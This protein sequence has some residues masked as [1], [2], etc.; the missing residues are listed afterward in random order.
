MCGECPV[1][2]RFGPSTVKPGELLIT[3]DSAAL[4]RTGASGECK[5]DSSLP[6]RL[7]GLAE[8]YERPEDFKARQLACAM[9]LKWSTVQTGPTEKKQFWSKKVLEC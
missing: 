8:K 3:C 2:R 6:L 5:Q 9:S 1:P 7:T 4:R